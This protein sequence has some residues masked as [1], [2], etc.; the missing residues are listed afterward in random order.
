MN[1]RSKEASI[2][3]AIRLILASV[4]CERA[5]GREVGE[6]SG[7]VTPGRSGA[8]CAEVSDYVAL[9]YLPCV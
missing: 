6:G 3:K 9:Y 5:R 8:S 7:A 1:R 4:W 2:A